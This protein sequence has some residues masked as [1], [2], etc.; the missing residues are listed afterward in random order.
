MGWGERWALGKGEEMGDN[1]DLSCV[2]Y[3]FVRFSITL[4]KGLLTASRVMLTVTP[5]SSRHNIYCKVQEK[6]HIYSKVQKN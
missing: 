6:Q 2:C 4:N 1:G 3:G 5:V